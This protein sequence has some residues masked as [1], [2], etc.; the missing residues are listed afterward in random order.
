GSLQ[1][2]LDSTRVLGPCEIVLI[3]EDV[4]ITL[5]NVEVSGGLVALER[6]FEGVSKRL[7]DAGVADK[8]V[9]SPVDLVGH[10]R[11]SPPAHLA[12]LAERLI[13]QVSKA[14][15]GPLVALDDHRLM[16]REICRIDLH[17]S[18]WCARL[19]RRAST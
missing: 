11:P 7:V 3:T 10:L 12:L 8:R 19:V 18:L 2:P 9:V 1:L 13:Q 16:G 15:V 6:I 17:N 14:H 5:G 4:Q